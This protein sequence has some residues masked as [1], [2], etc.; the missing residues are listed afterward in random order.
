MNVRM[1]VAGPVQISSQWELLVAQ[2]LSVGLNWIQWGIQC[3]IY[4][5]PKVDLI[6]QSYVKKYFKI[7]YIFC[8]SKLCKKS[9]SKRCW[10]STHWNFVEQ[11]M[12]KWWKFLAYRNLIKGR[13]LKQRRFLSIKITS[14][15]VHQD[16]FNFCP[17]KLHKKSHQ[18]DV[19]I[20]QYSLFDVWT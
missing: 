4:V 8:P 12:P 16:N 3:S 13:M 9:A 1:S 2:L 19:E 14:K 7:T 18:N 11:S 6:Y 10:F 20:C 15:K 17:L 5:H